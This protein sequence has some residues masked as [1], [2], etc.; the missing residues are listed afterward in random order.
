MRGAVLR[1][2]PPASAAPYQIGLLG[3]LTSPEEL[4]LGPCCKLTSRRL[5][6]EG[7]KRIVWRSLGQPRTRIEA[8]YTVKF[9][10]R[11]WLSM[12]LLENND[13]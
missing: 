1:L 8:M 6:V 10:L 3:R 5:G 2:P 9:F 4:H 11:A 7:K 13:L 12:S